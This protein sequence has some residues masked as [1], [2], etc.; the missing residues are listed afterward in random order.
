V[1]KTSLLFATLLSAGLTAGPAQVLEIDSLSPIQGCTVSGTVSG[2]APPS[3]FRV[4]VWAYTPPASAGA[5]P[6]K[7]GVNVLATSGPV[8]TLTGCDVARCPAQ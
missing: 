2:V 6:A 7:D 4:L 5:L 3:A 8:G 1:L